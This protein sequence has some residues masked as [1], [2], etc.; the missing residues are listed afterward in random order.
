MAAL[1]TLQTQKSRATDVERPVKRCNNANTDNNPHVAALQ[2][3]FELTPE[4]TR[5][6]RALPSLTYW[7]CHL[8]ECFQPLLTEQ[9]ATIWTTLG[10][11]RPRVTA[12]CWDLFQAVS[13][14]VAQLDDA[15]HSI[16]DVWELTRLPP[17]ADAGQHPLAV[18]AGGRGDQSLLVIFAVLCWSSMILQPELRWTKAAVAPCL[19]IQQPPAEPQSL[20]MDFVQRPIPAVFRN[21]QNALARQRLTR[22]PTKDGGTTLFV[23]TINYHSLRIIGKVSLKWVDDLSC[24]LSLD[25]RTRTLSVFRLP[26]FCACTTI[27]G[28]RGVLFEEFV[29][30]SILPKSMY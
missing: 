19:A 30:T 10:F 21:F 9:Y 6:V 20:K 4:Q 7:C 15:G 5:Q 18:P 14:V 29:P 16:E 2:A 25:S 12:Q 13:R 8:E 1:R 26:S 22:K 27:G 3:L 23:S 11:P 28:D 17:G 24:H